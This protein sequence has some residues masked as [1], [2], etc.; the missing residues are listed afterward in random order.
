MNSTSRRLQVSRR[1]LAAVFCVTL[2]LTG[3][4]HSNVF[5]PEPGSVK[6]LDWNIDSL[7]YGDTFPNNVEPGK[8][9]IQRISKGLRDAR[10]MKTD[11]YSDY[12]GDSWHIVLDLQ[13][14]YMLWID[15]A[16]SNFSGNSWFQLTYLKM[17]DKHQLST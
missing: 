7:T 4:G 9:M 6:T 8:S 16:P 2:L 13:N 15:P 11:P 5:T 17:N 10:Q 1:F 3:C 14:G 12:I